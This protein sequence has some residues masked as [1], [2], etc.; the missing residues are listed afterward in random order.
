MSLRTDLIRL[1][2]EKPALRP[3]ILPLLKE[4]K[5]FSSQAQ[6][7]EYIDSLETE[8]GKERARK[9]HTVEEKGD[10]PLKDKGVLGNLW[11]IIKDLAGSLGR[12]KK[13][14]DSAKED[15]TAMKK[16]I[17]EQVG[18]GG[19][20][21]EDVEF[22]VV[23]GD[24]GC[25]PCDSKGKD[26]F[27]KL[28]VSDA[29]AKKAMASQNKENKAVASLKKTQKEHDA[30]KAEYEKAEKEQKSKGKKPKENG[31]L[32]I[33][34][35]GQQKKKREDMTKAELL[36]EYQEAIKKSDMSPEDKKK[37]LEK[38]KKPNFDPEAALG[39]MGDEDED[40]G[41]TAM[42]LR[43]KIIRLAHEKPELRSKLLPLLKESSDEGEE[44]KAGP[45]KRPGGK[46][47]QFM[48]EM[49]D[50]KVR[51]PDTGN[52]VKLKSLKGEKGKKLQ[53]EKFEKWLASQEKDGGKKEDK[54]K[55]DKKEDKP[56]SKNFMDPKDYSDA[57]DA[58]AYVDMDDFSK[59]I[60]GIKGFM[61]GS[62]RDKMNHAGKLFGLSEKEIEGHH[63]AKNGDKGPDIKE[64]PGFQT[65]YQAL[66]RAMGD[67]FNS[68]GSS[69]EGE[70]MDF[71]NE[72]NDA[73][74]DEKAALRTMGTGSRNPSSKSQSAALKMISKAVKEIQKQI[75]DETNIDIKDGG[76]D[77][78]WAK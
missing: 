72:F 21:P 18:W 19:M 1:A 41:K 39:A 10:A 50:E 31:E 47:V 7:D 76:Y 4:A 57:E 9:T 54:P 17:M 64:I 74:G 35:R 69:V 61:S 48:K 37:A 51:N 3:K 42:S 24:F 27:K 32:P 78:K 49:G 15:N 52:D 40:E 22:V 26:G 71:A 45:S 66:N 29:D 43:S 67:L 58:S 44:A 8:E 70:M 77:L 30:K 75:A 20:N 33:G 38:S 5:A 62:S 28:D 16:K 60:S 2:Y 55:S 56:K 13:E 6:L 25:R 59:S 11:Q 34:D 65:A 73:L 53:K 12:K 46:F 23:D 36:K 14:A 68:D 63:D